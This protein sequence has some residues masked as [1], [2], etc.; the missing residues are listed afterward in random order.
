MKGI[1]IAGNGNSVW[2]RTRLI[3]LGKWSSWTEELGQRKDSSKLHDQMIFH[4]KKKSLNWFLIE[5]RRK[6]STLRTRQSHEIKE[7]EL[8]R[9]RGQSKDEIPWKKCNQSWLKNPRS[10]SLNQVHSNQD[11][12]QLK[13]SFHP[14]CIRLFQSSLWIPT[15]LEN[16]DGPGAPTKKCGINKI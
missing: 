8:N 5:Q 6:K 1:R 13:A 11:M 9:S 2:G 12:E 15:A 10:L 3:F 16:P 4:G 7:V 14:T